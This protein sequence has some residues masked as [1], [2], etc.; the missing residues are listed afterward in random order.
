MDEPD[1]LEQIT[2][3]AGWL[4]KSGKHLLWNLKWRWVT[5]SGE[6][7]TWHFSVPGQHKESLS[8]HMPLTAIWAC[9]RSAA[10]K[11][12]FC[13]EVFARGFPQTIFVA[14]DGPS[15]ERWIEAINLAICPARGLQ[16]AVRGHQ[17]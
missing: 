10:L 8:G 15:A 6:G 9:R 17:S 11:R 7:L 14:A 3:H 16:V 2:G 5:L 12:A 13:F 1:T 4:L